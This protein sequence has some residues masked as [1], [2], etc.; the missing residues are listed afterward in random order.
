LAIPSSKPRL[1]LVVVVHRMPDQARRTLLSLSVRHQRDV[2]EHDYE[3]IVVENDSERLLG[4]RAVV[5]AGKN[6]R[7]FSRAEASSSPAAAVNFGVGHARAAHVAIVVDGARL[8][9]PGVVGNMLL[10]LA[11]A[12]GAVVAVP[13]YHLGSELQQRAVRSGYDEAAEARL[14]EAIGWPADGYR[15]FEVACLSGSCAGG[16]L[17]PMAESTC[18]GMP[19]V[20]FDAIGGCDLA[21]DLPG[22]GFVNLDL[23]R[24]VC[25]LDETRLFVLPGEGTFHQFHGG[26]TTGGVL[27]E[28]E[29]LLDRMGDQYRRLRGRPFAAPLKT[30]H[31]FGVVPPQAR[32]FL[33]HSLGAVEAI[34]PLELRP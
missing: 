10:A 27:A 7:Y 17:A 30:P 4:S 13:G 18:L 33:E 26:V 19:R 3:V 2:T 23:Y 28:R 32:R 9:S 21:F 15:L 34:G 25:E 22:G 29:Q 16:F 14:L 24:R 12:A 8:A 5:E 6:F 11:A 1:S 20:V 31:L